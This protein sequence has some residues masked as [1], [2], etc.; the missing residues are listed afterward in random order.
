MPEI[1]PP[2][3]RVPSS[4]NGTPELLRYFTNL[5]MFLRQLWQKTGG[6]DD[7]TPVGVIM[8]WDGTDVPN[9]WQLCDGTNG[10]PNL[11]DYNG[12]KFMQ[13]MS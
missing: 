7:L 2:P 3:S 1:N 13:R 9:R 10:T 5:H 12:A 4:F 8:L 6:S 11:P